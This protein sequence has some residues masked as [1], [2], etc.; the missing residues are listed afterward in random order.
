M[1]FSELRP[2]FEDIENRIDEQE[3]QQIYDSWREFSEGSCQG[4]PFV[5]PKRKKHPAKITW[6]RVFVNDALEDENLMLLGQFKNCSDMLEN[7]SGNILWV[8]PNYG[9]G[10]LPSLFGA[11]RFIMPYDT[12]CLPNVRPLSGGG[13]ALKAVLEKGQLDFRQGYG[14]QVFD[15]GERLMEIKSRFPKIGRYVFIDHP[16]CQ[17]PM[18]ICELLCGNDI[19]FMPY[20]DEDLLL[21]LLG[22]VTKVYLDFLDKWFRLCPNNDGY[23]CFFGRM[24]KGKVTIRD[25]SAMNLSPE[26]FEKFIFP[27]DQQI[28]NKFGGAIHFCGRGDHFIKYMPRFEGLYGVDVSQ[29]HLNDMDIILKNTVNKNINL[30]CVRGEW[31]E[32]LDGNEYLLNRL[33]LL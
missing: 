13:T 19:F 29:P 23:H 10:I 27:F 22:G 16:D 6:P 11:E 14:S 25:D 15:I 21:Y 32:H 26:F 24:H 17:G 4:G 5:P 18:D 8:R 3:E 30:L 31:S 2:Y 33:S 7:G 1:D 9:V 20:E 28:L 12:N